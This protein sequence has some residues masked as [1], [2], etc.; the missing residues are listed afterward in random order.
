MVVRQIRSALTSG[1][2]LTCELFRQALATVTTILTERFWDRYLDLRAALVVL[3]QTLNG[4]VPTLLDFLPLQTPAA[5][6]VAAAD[7]ARM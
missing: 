1:G 3:M 5:A 7:A 6:F 4:R 2:P